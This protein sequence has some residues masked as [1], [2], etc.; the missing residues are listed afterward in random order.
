[1]KNTPKR[2][3]NFFNYR[4]GDIYFKHAR[5]KMKDIKFYDN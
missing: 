3:I 1:M 2:K 5:K 4:F